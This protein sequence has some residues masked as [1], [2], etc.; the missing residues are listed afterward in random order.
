MVSDVGISDEVD[1]ESDVRLLPNIGLVLEVD[2][3]ANVG[4]I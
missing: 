3:G 4:L 2:P 1:L